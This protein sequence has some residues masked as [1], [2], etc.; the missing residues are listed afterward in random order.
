MINS[1]HTCTCTTVFSF[2][3]CSANISNISPI[4]CWFLGQGGCKEGVGSDERDR[5]SC[6]D[7]LQHEPHQELATAPQSPHQRS[8][9]RQL[10]A[11]QKITNSRK[12]WKIRNFQKIRKNR[13]IQKIREIWKIWKI[14]KTRKDWKIWKDR[15]R[16]E[17]Q[18]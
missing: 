12:I 7:H 18:E 4:I 10:L 14:R 8:V 15:E 3:V 1:S 13:K 11:F 2:V 6:C 16:E 17:E 9:L 5:L